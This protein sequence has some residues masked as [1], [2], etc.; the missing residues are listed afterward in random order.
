MSR[1]SNVLFVVVVPIRGIRVF[2][3]LEGEQ[4]FERSGLKRRDNNVLSKRFSV[5]AESPVE[6]M[7][8]KPATAGSNVTLLIPSDGI[9]PNNSKLPVILYKKAVTLEGRDP[10]ANFER[11]FTKNGWGGGWRDGIFPFHHYHTTA[12]EVLGIF[13]GTATVRL[14]GDTTAGHTVQ[15]AAGDVVVIPIGVAHKNLGSSS[16]FACV[17]AYPDGTQPDMNYGKPEE[18]R[19][20][21]ETMRRVRLPLNDPLSGVDGLL[22]QKW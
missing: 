14:G 11:A 6:F 3:Q 20:S 16:D 7:K 1:I 13:S 21:E 2:R 19:K 15:V 17:G 18:L 22:I 9:F 4:Y 8:T 5:K 12:H 10:A